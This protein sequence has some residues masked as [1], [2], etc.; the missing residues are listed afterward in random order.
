MVIEL[1]TIVAILLMNID[2]YFTSGYWWL[3]MAIILMAI[4]GCSIVR[5]CWVLLDIYGYY[6]NGY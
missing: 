3:L 2:G 5:Y 4:G 6:M 1:L